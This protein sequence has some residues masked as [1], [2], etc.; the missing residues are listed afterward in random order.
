M[1]EK[2]FKIYSILH[3]FLRWTQK[4]TGSYSDAMR[5]IQE[6]LHT[7]MTSTVRKFEFK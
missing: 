7:S 2:S 6:L 4:N 3:L 1:A 5:A